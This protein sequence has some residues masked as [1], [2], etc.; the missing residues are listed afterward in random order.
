MITETE[1]RQCSDAL[2]EWFKSQGCDPADGSLAMLRLMAS[3]LVA[4]TT[5]TAELDVAIRHVML[6]LALNIAEQLSKKNASN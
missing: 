1:T 3:Q 6:V 4:K 5:D 2:I